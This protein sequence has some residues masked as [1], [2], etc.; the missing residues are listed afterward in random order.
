MWLRWPKMDL[1]NARS[2]EI[3]RTLG[4]ADDLR[5]QGQL[6][7]MFTAMDGIV[8]LTG[9]G[10]PSHF[11]YTCRVSTG[12]NEKENVTAWYLDSVDNYREKIVRNNDGSMP[13]EPYQRLSQA[14]FEAWLYKLCDK[15]PLIDLRFGWKI[16]SVLETDIETSVTVSNAKTGKS[17][18]VISRFIG[19]CDGAS[20]KI[21]RGLAIP[22][23]GGPV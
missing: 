2:M 6:F 13:L 22:L 7:S 20:S 9:S 12:L 14:V 10:V 8:W 1:T 4:L 17:R 16:E 18:K 3:F 19:A 23:D 15:N 21:R 11:P 5:K